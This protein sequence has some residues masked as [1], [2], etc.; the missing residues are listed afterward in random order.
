MSTNISSV[1]AQSVATIA[2]TRFVCKALQIDRTAK[3]YDSGTEIVWPNAQVIKINTRLGPEA[4]TAIIHVPVSDIE[5]SLGLPSDSRT[6][7]P[8]AYPSEIMRFSAPA[9]SGGEAGTLTNNYMFQQVRIYEW[10]ELLDDK[11]IKSPVFIGYIT[12]YEWVGA[13]GTTNMVVTLSDARFFAHKAPIQG[14]IFYNPEKNE[15][16]YIRAHHPVFNERSLPNRYYLNENINETI[17]PRFVN[18]DLNRFA[19]SPSDPRYRQYI[20]ER[21]VAYYTAIGNIGVPGKPHA[22]IWLPVHAWNYVR[23]LMTRIQIETVDRPNKTDLGRD[24]CPDDYPV[25]L[26]KVITIKPITPTG[27]PGSMWNDWATPRAEVGATESGLT[28]L[29]SGLGEMDPQGIN[30]IEFLHELC[31]QVG[32]YTLAA[33]YDPS[34]RLII[35]PIRTTLASDTDQSDKVGLNGGTGG[36]GGKKASLTMPPVSGTVGQENARS[37]VESWNIQQ[38]ADNYFNRAFLHGGRRFVQLTLCTCGTQSWRDHLGFEHQVYNP[39]ADEWAP[40]T[41]HGTL[42]PGWNAD[43]QTQWMLI[44]DLDTDL[45]QFPDVFRAWIVPANVDWTV[46]WRGAAAQP[47]YRMYFERDRQMMDNLLTRIFDTTQGIYRGR[48]TQLKYQIWRAYQ[49]IR[50]SAGE[51]IDAYGDAS[52]N[53]VAGKYRWFK[54]AADAELFNDGRLGF[55]LDSNAR[56]RNDY[57]IEDAD[58]DPALE[59]P[60]SWNGLQDQKQPYEMM[61]TVSVEVDEDLYSYLSLKLNSGGGLAIQQYGFPQE[62][63]RDSGMEY[64]EERVVR[65][66]VDN[67][68]GTANDFHFRRTV[69]EGPNTSEL[70]RNGMEELEARA[71]IIA[72][73]HAMLDIEGH[74]RL[75]HIAT[76]IVPG[77]YIRSL[78]P[79]EARP[80][81]IGA[82]VVEADHDVVLQKTTLTLAT[83]R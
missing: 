69:P 54:L 45:E 68:F 24:P 63:H 15:V 65:C 29:I 81:T 70:Y 4:G 83:I 28:K 75:D 7:N 36:T 77:Q 49:G 59:S 2:A 14:K 67:P 41:I 58:A 52:G 13:P 43:D 55:R 21:E 66:Q 72:N 19:S 34:G 20:V 64:K 17:F 80:I 60:W 22:R 73:R 39:S 3:D 46:L 8:D 56:F 38:T 26:G 37:E 1:P 18:T 44:R 25:D 40:I 74:V 30:A 33:T 35:E 12:K 50:I 82:L 51:D 32:N 23:W 42:A 79:I 76:D 10:E 71:R 9:G 31:R 62:I 57:K 78:E 47:G 53:V 6:F 27:V 61:L 16:V 5:S 48:P 11:E